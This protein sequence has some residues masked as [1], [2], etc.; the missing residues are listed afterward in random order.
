ME[1]W[2]TRAQIK[3]WGEIQFL[4]HD[5]SRIHGSLGELASQ[6]LSSY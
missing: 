4:K 5:P 1:D 2:R 3:V 6:S